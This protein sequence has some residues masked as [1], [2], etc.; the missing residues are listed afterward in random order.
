MRNLGGL[1]GASLAIAVVSSCGGGDGSAGNVGTQEVLSITAA[2]PPVGMTGLAYP[3]YTFAATGGT[4]PIKWTES[5]PV[6]PGLRISASGQ[7]SGMPVTAGTY[8]VLVTGTDSSTPPLTGNASVS[9]VIKDSPIVLATAA[10][11]PGTVSCTYPG[12]SFVASGGS[13]PIT[14]AASDLPAGLTLAKNGSLSGTPA[15]AG[16]FSFSVI[17]TDSA[18]TP[19]S[20]PPLAAQIV[21][22]SSVLTL[23]STPAPPSGA[24]GATYGPFAFS[25]TG[26]CQPL[27]W[28]VTQGTLPPGLMLVTDGV[29]FGTPT[30]SGTFTFTVKIEDGAPSPNESSVQF[31]INVSP[32]KAVQSLG[33]PR[34]RHSATQLASGSLLIAGGA[35]GGSSDT[36]TATATAELYDPSANAT[37][38]TGLMMNAREAHTA[39][40]LTQGL[41]A[42]QVLITGGSAG[43]SSLQ[44]AELYDPVTGRFTATGN[45]LSPRAYHTATLLP[46]G[47]VLIAGGTAVSV[48]PVLSAEV[49]DPATGEF[50]A[51]GNMV[52]WHSAHAAALLANGKVLIVGG[53]G[54]EAELYDPASKAFTSTGPMVQERYSLTATTLASGQVLITGGIGSTGLPLSS[55]EIY[56]PASGEFAE[57]GN[58]AAARARHTAVLRGD[59]S[60]L[61]VGG[62]SHIHMNSPWCSFSGCPLRVLEPTASVEVY[63]PK[64]GLF[65]TTAVLAS[66]R[67]SH[68][69]TLL[70]DGAVLIAGG[71][72]VKVGFKGGS[73]RCCVVYDYLAVTASVDLD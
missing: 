65:A 61:I 22:N 68:T 59:G 19:L 36:A 30:V 72:V 29:L 32:S 20:A 23:D 60:V 31:T 67:D 69:A 45:M 66:G 54:T 9:L 25:A 70:A 39:T 8:P 63:N 49:Y 42:G 40:L 12:F 46:T 51:T 17:A 27:Q 11:P 13:P 62:S 1:F 43:G 50:A 35:T 26:G 48:A 14:W 3:G 18:Q 4:P 44:T 47:Q 71:E 2:S 15:S 6:P 24:Q 73:T 57:I 58:M 21:I 52:A 10:P 41:R 56:D 53:N 7:V 5:G 34:V 38:P 37:A 16:A 55:A 28:S 33:L 64:T